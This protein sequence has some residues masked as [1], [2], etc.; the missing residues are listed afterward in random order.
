[1][2]EQVADMSLNRIEQGL[3]DYILGHPEERQYW[4]GKVQSIAGTGDLHTVATRLEV[5]LWRYQQERSAVVPQLRDDARREGPGRTSL[6]NLA[7]HCLRQWGPPR[8][9][10]SAQPGDRP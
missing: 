4:Q 7:E 2:P 1:M 3:F 10:P 8:P 9:P 6:R 5:E